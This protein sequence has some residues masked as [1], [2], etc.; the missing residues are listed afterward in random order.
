M[1]RTVF[2]TCTLCE[3]MCG[4]GFEVEGERILSV[5]A[6]EEDV[7][8]QGYICPKGAAIAAV[9]DDPDRL[10][11]PVRRTPSG[12]FEPISWDDAL[13]I[14]AR[15]LKEIRGEHGADAI[16]LYIG[17]PV[18]HNH[19]ALALRNGL[20]RAIG[21]RNCT[22]AGSQDTSPRFAASYYLYGSSL[23]IPVPDI[24]RTAYFLCLGANPRISNGSFM[25]A[26]NIR[27]R[28]QAI[29]QRGGKVVVVDP[30]R[31]ETAREAD[32]HIAILP[33]A[34]RRSCCRSR[35]SWLTRSGSIGRGSS[36]WP[37]VGKRSSAV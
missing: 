5:G 21:T 2:R 7:F 11:A 31:T 9:H 29:R 1:S 12:D 13:S 8:S 23:S 6:D 22:S 32:E 36:E 17:N 4:L 37:M 24:D 25:T 33:G 3:A 10:R 16:A 18:A 26:P 14:V 15:R 28:L 30:R 20:F 34:M 19:G 35:T 27:K